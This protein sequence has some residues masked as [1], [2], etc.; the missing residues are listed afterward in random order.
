[1]YVA[2]VTKDK[3]INAKNKIDETP[4]LSQEQKDGSDAL[5]PAMKGK[6]I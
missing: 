3:K 5:K 4:G 6:G 1:M 2:A